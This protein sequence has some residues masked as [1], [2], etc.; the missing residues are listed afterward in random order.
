MLFTIPNEGELDAHIEEIDLLNQD[1]K[2]TITI[3]CADVKESKCRYTDFN[4]EIRFKRHIASA[5]NGTDHIEE[6]VQQHVSKY[7]SF[8]AN[9]NL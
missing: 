8:E 7:R 4:L 5:R 6:M 9:V 3:R 1:Q 2:P